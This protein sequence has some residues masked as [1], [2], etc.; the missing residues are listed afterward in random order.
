MTRDDALATLRRLR[1]SLQVRGVAHA[2]LFGSVARG[3]ATRGS[4]VDIVVTPSDG[5]RLDLID[6]GGIQTVLDEAFG[7]DVD[8]IVEPVRK[9]EL[10]RAIERD[11]ANAF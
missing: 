7:T 8:V 9:R 11:R 3:Q 2:A 1:P 6:L 10:R 5:A 4:D